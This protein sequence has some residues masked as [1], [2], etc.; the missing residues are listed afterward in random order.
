MWRIK[1]AQNNAD[2]DEGESVNDNKNDKNWNE[3]Q[4]KAIE[5]L[6]TNDVV[7]IFAPETCGY[8]KEQFD[9]EKSNSNY[10]N[11]DRQ[12]IEKNA[13][14]SKNNKSHDL[15]FRKTDR[16][17]SSVQSVNLLKE[18]V[19]K[20]RKQEDDNLKEEGS[21]LFRHDI[22]GL[23]HD[24]LMAKVVQAK[25]LKNGYSSTH[26]NK[27]DTPHRNVSAKEL[28]KLFRKT[29]KQLKKTKRPKLDIVDLSMNECGDIQETDDFDVVYVTDDDE[30]N[31]YNK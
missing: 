29:E 17:A 26:Q 2:F 19:E 31:K 16:L 9:Y 12:H 4:G 10:S 14:Y 15:D 27:L 6:N 7:K 21:S 1:V 24:H 5:S 13:I 30:P 23:Q 3:D 8:L 22:Y 20:S 11:I 28:S 25:L 18:K